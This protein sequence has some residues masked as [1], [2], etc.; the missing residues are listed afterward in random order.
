MG[1]MMEKI[2]RLYQLVLSPVVYSL[3]GGCRFY[4]SCS[5]Y[6]RDAYKKHGFMKGSLLTL[7]RI[8]RC[9]PFSAGGIDPVR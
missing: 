6:S 3:G 1:W 9:N 8:L 2:V 5:C 4:P 7:G